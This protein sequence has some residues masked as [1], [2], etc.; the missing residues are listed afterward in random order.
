MSLLLHAKMVN[1]PVK[2]LVLAVVVEDVVNV[3][4]REMAVPVV[5]QVWPVVVVFMKVLSVGNVGVG[6]RILLRE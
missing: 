2:G 3:Y 5:G 1:I 4:R 6:F